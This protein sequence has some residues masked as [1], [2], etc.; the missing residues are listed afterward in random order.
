MT[1]PLPATWGCSHGSGFL[2]GAIRDAEEQMSH[3]DHQASWAGHCFV[4]V[5][6]QLLNGTHQPCIVEAEWPAVKLSPVTAH[7]DA[8]WATGQPL[9]ASQRNLGVDKALALVGTSYGWPAYAYFLARVIQLKWTKDLT[10]IFGQ[11]NVIIC[12]GV[13]VACL[14][15]MAVNLG[16]LRT[17][18]VQ[19]P[20]FICPADLLRWGLDHQWMASLPPASWR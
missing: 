10:T 3:G 20:S 11:Q 5:G 18:A 16:P 19:D 12:S 17:A 9:S 7:P 13:V 1:L 8:C 2:G 4:F 15:A 14:Q 6:N